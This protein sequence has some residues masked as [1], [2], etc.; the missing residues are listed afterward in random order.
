MRSAFFGKNKEEFVPDMKT[1]YLIDGDNNIG[2][3]LKGIDLLTPEDHVLIFYQNAQALAGIKKLCAGSEADIRY[4]ESVRSGRNSVDFQIIT[5]LGVLVGRR[6]VDCAYVISQ[7]QGYAAS[8]SA[9]R[10]RFSD[11]FQEVA[12]RPSIEEC[13]HL[14]FLLRTG[15]QEE[16][17][18]ALTRECGA[19]Q[20]RAL[21]EHLRR[22]FSVE[23]ERRRSD[24]S[25]HVRKTAGPKKKCVKSTESEKSL[26]P[27]APV[28]AVHTRRSSRRRKKNPDLD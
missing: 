3:G 8:I 1:F 21:C 28:K 4:I 18:D 20:G 10:A 7:D 16:L 15:N 2:T 26:E 25:E 14:A 24:E 6:E 9:L 19:A 22:I 12:L 23:E 27:I 13:L 11:S 17:L 5:E